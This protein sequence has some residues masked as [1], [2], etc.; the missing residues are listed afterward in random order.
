MKKITSLF[1]IL[2]FHLFP[3]K[4]QIVIEQVDFN[5]Y[6]SPTDND[7]VNRFNNG[8]GLAQIT[9]NGITGGCLTVP[10]TMN[11]G[12]D[13]AVYCSKY[14]ANLGSYCKTNIAFKYDTALF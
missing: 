6:I 7:F 5:N 13:N 1:F 9:T 8:A 4:G 10:A 11:W 12:N 2:A 14:I 3:A